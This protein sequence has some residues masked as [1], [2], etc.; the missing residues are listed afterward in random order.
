MSCVICFNNFDDDSCK[1]YNIC[2]EG[3][4]LC[5]DCFN[6]LSRPKKCPT[7][8]RTCRSSPILTRI[9]A[10]K[11]EEKKEDEEEEDEEEEE[12]EEEEIPELD[13]RDVVVL[14]DTSGSMDGKSGE[15][16]NDP[17]RIELVGHMMKILLRFCRKLKKN[18]IFYEFNSSLTR[19]KI[20]KNTIE[21]TAYKIIE[22]MEPQNCTN[23]GSAL[24]HL[25]RKCGD[26]TIYFVLTDGESSDETISA[27][28]EYENVDLH[29]IAFSQDVKCTL[30]NQV[31]EC[32][33]HTIS[34]VQ[35]IDSLMGYIIPTFVW[36]MTSRYKKTLSD[37]DEEIR[38]EYVRLLEP[39][40]NGSSS[41]YSINDLIKLVGKP[42]TPYAKDLKVDTV[43]DARHGRVYYSFKNNTNWNTF[44][45]FYLKC[46]LHCHKHKIPGN[47]F[48]LSLQ[49]Y[50]TEEYEKVYSYLS[51]E[52]EK[53]EFVA[54]RASQNVRA[55]VSQQSRARVTKT[56][57]YVDTYRSSSYSDD[58]DGCI[59]GN[60]IISLK[61]GTKLMKDLQPGDELVEGKVKWIIQIKN[62]NQGKS[63]NTY[64]G[65]TKSH[66]VCEN[67]VWKPAEK[68]SN[69]LVKIMRGDDIVYDVVLDDRKVGH[70]LVNGIQTAVVGYPVPGMVH[71]YWGSSKILC[72][73]EQRCPGGGVVNVDGRNFTI[74]N[75]LVS[76]IFQ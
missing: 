37:K 18:C 64:N 50:R 3:H 67:G 72:D 76:N 73:I 23:L 19:L 60:A 11:E 68:Y 46:I 45:K 36:A 62:L 33:N 9:N 48:D 27:I 30:L 2:E 24:M 8:R 12:E 56:I 31:A 39:Q 74:T 15:N 69:A 66:P 26:N 43:E 25:H 51:G 54:F 40:V 52:A 6:S 32:E 17:K 55:Q 22:Q 7:C 10:V 71:P 70:M 61:N 75:G 13:D 21:E 59:E 53:I 57:Q 16:A 28:K 5:L 41:K 63:F 47:A 29:L 35:S 42:V 34:Y 49:H 38:C 1:C 14:I 65:L 20:N 58:N 4:T 44:G